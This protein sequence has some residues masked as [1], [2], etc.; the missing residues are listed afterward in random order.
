MQVSNE[1]IGSLVPHEAISRRILLAGTFALGSAALILPQPSKAAPK[2]GGTLRLG[3][4]EGNSIDSLDPLTYKSVGMFMAGVTLGNCLVELDSAGLPV[5]ELAESWNVSADAATWTFKIR[6]GVTFHNGRPLTTAD[7]V[8]SLRR[9]IGA[10]TTSPLKSLLSDVKDISADGA[11]SV[12]VKLNKGDSDIDVIMSQWQLVIVPEGTKDFS[13]FNGTGPYV[14]KTFE[15][16]VRLVATRNPNYWKANRAWVENVEFIFIDDGAARVNAL[17]SGQL[18]AINQ[19]QQRII[20]RLKGRGGIKIVESIGAKFFTLAMAT[21]STSFSNN[22]VR[23]AVKNALPRKEIV[24]STLSGFG[25]VGNDHPVPPNSPWLNTQLPQFEADPDKAKWHLKQ[26]GRDSVS[27]DLHT[28]SLVYAGATDASV[29]IKER[30]A[31]LGINIKVVNQPADGYWSNVWRKYDF[32]MVRWSVRPTPALTFGLG[33]ACTSSMNETGWCDTRFEKL[34]SEAKVTTNADRK[35][36]LYWEMQAIQRETGG[37]SVFAFPSVLDA[38]AGT[39][40][41]FEPDTVQEMFG[42]R[43]AERVWMTA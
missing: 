17:M 28:S 21:G 19:V 2:R 6:Q 20:S 27:V 39:V 5:P 11:R 22:H 8:W 16:G 3:L 23:L 43:V 33:Y 24:A 12:V 18:D 32:V 29:T 25:A 30:L 4:S 15:P 34:L 26:A 41:G 40:T 7:V 36:Q 13:A 14:L 9:H 1:V 38:Y 42:C 31:P 10:T 37:S 35:R